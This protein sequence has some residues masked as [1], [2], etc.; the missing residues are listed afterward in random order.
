ME[1]GINADQNFFP[2]NQYLPPTSSDRNPQHQRAYDPPPLLNFDQRSPQLPPKLPFLTT[3]NLQAVTA[4]GYV[5]GGGDRDADEFYRE[6]R[7]VQQSSSS[8]T[9]MAASASES[10]PTV[11]PLRSNGN[12]TTPKHPTIPNART[13][14][15][16]AYRSASSPLDDRTG[17]NNAKSSP[18][19]NG[20]PNSRQPSV[21]DLLKRFDQNNSSSGSEA[22]KPPG[23]LATRGAN[24]GPGY[25]K[26][27]VGYQART[28]N[29]PSTA[30][31]SRIGAS[32]SHV[33]PNRQKSPAQTRTQR[34]RFATE[35]QHSNNTLSGAAR[36]TRPRNAPSGSIS[37]ASKSMVNLSPT[38]PNA[39]SQTPNRRPLFG[40]VIGQGTPDIAYGIPRGP[41]RRTSDSNL[42]PNSAHRRSKSDFDVS[43]SSPTAWYLGVTPALDDV[44]T[45]K[46]RATPGH[47]R[48]HS[49]FADTKVNTMNGVS[50][51]FQN[52]HSRSPSLQPSASRLPRATNRLSGGSSDSSSLPSTRANSPFSTKK[53]A[54]G[55]PPKPDQRPW[56]PAGRA[57]TPT[58]R[59]KTPT[60]RGLRGKSTSPGK[61]NTNSSLKAYISA[62]LLKTS[63]PLRSSR[64][65]QPV[66]SAA[67]AA[68]AKP[69]PTE[70]SSSP[71]Q[72]RSGMKL[73]RNMGGSEHKDRKISDT[74]LTKEDF[75]ARRAEI[76]RA[77]TKSIAL[78]D[79]NRIR[80]NNLRRLQERQA[81]DLA[82]AEAA[83]AAAEKLAEAP[84]EEPLRE[85][86]EE[87]PASQPPLHL[88]TSFQTPQYSHNERNQFPADQDSPTLGM[89]GTFIDD[90]EPASAISNAT[91]EIDN[92]P[93][94]E[95]ARLSR[96]P[97]ARRERSGLSSHVTYMENGLSAEQALFGSQH[98]EDEDSITI[99]LEPPTAVDAP[100]E[101][102]PTNNKFSRD[103]S[104]PGAYED[105]DY[106]DYNQPVFATTLT[107]ASPLD[108]TPGHSEAI[109]PL[110]VDQPQLGYDD[111]NISDASEPGEMKQISQIAPEI[112][113][114]QEP[115][116][117]IPESTE[118][119]PRF[120]LP[121]LRTALA[122]PSLT[123]SDVSHDY[124][125]TPGTDIEY[126]SSDGAAANA[127]SS[128]ERDERDGELS[129]G[130]KR[131][132]VWSDYNRE[133][134]A[135]Q[136][137][138]S[139]WTDY[140]VDT[141][142]EYSEREEHAQPPASKF[143]SAS[144]P[145]PP[146]PTE[147][148]ESTA[149]PQSKL[150]YSP[151]PSPRF[152]IGIPQRESSNRHQLPPLST[153]GS[154]A[155]E[156]SDSSP[157]FANIPLPLWPNYSP[158]PPPH[159]PGESSPALSG[160]SPPPPS[161]YNRRPP[162]SLYQSSQNGARNPESRRASDDL[163]SPR[164][165]SSTPRSS[166][167]ISFEESSADQSLKLKSTTASLANEEEV[168][169]AAKD[170]KR[171][172]R[173]RLVIKELIDTESVYLK[174]M[175]VVE[176]IYKGTAEACPKLETGDIKVIF[177]N[178]DEIV[179]FSTMFLDELKSAGSSVYSPRPT[180]PRRNSKGTASPIRDDRSS[181][182]PTLSEETDEQKDRKT[183]I[184]ANFGKH[185]KRMQVIY[186]DFLKNSEV[187]SSRL[188]ALQTDNSVKV[189]LGE[190]NLV[191]KDLT[192][193]WDLD[194]L[195]VKPVQ[196]ITRYQLLLAEIKKT[197]PDNHP[198]YEAL[199]LSTQELGTLLQN[200]DDLKK[201]I[202]M[203]GKIVGRKRKESDVRSGL[204]KAFGRAR[205]AKV[206]A[207][208]NRPRDDELYVKLHEKFGDDY[209]RL[210][211]VLRDVEFYTR[212]V[213][214]W[215]NDFLRYLSSMELIMRMTASPYPEL[216][217]KWARFNMSMRDMGT[218]A[219][220][221]HVSCCKPCVLFAD[222][223]S[224]DPQRP[225]EGHRTI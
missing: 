201:R 111:V 181:V 217:S 208:P 89:P 211:V 17:L 164:A 55:K 189:W 51:S 100:A 53:L 125:N 213:T 142:D 98:M 81:H 120:Q 106:T 138:T 61:I 117:E 219:L 10:R 224:S 119:A 1:S 192:A 99:M 74:Q 92:E 143:P 128:E 3:R 156:F 182:A 40:E 37:Q 200:I 42:Q 126:E 86:T 212:Q 178:T 24:A 193:A 52:S 14:L 216:E 11:S 123:P 210:Q 190:C 44:D 159:Q 116:H 70:P 135:E 87:P 28:T 50:P 132:S 179:A 175:N 136:K 7:G 67:T 163:Y 194:A 150:E 145:A 161:L 97:S 60:G 172:E 85:P 110:S 62:P 186:T 91:T 59:A 31:T 93:Q 221:D 94:T 133:L 25:A 58:N 101:P 154:F 127:V 157:G 191:A 54:N 65:R 71:K 43:P 113:L 151:L 56:S 23:R 68:A 73:T 105:D 19:L 162:S 206:Q 176:E 158:P 90:D 18:A 112:S 185:L 34:T 33:P 30:G 223:F 13:G 140:S 124:L 198:D 84:S 148:A 122:P 167:Q 95:A 102:T 45:N 180:K 131:R 144:R 75:A 12:G 115:E 209:L 205:E 63:P 108:S 35:D 41:T 47:N 139:V 96:M 147:Q 64:P 197:T 152:P 134:S 168:K 195:L 220:E 149:E 5:G 171:L 104:P 8:F 20:Y 222:F 16:P 174:D 169:V 173:R 130:Q 21:K 32:T 39:P 114:Q 187:A 4:N 155:Q 121:M 77:Y 80:A 22:P 79:Q 146:P 184:G 48:N 137:R 9:D 165:S 109:S 46:T 103:P 207:N 214:N 83:K 26:E 160:R 129:P 76:H 88:T 170:Q 15:K 49:D 188:A 29:T 6:Y 27:R 196:R 141:G 166:T 78:E 36:P 57:V 2:R 199:A 204:A 82:V 215:T 177:R 118:E 107:A 38:S 153:S 203:V 218:I 225:Q 72:A 66:S 183:F 202:H 69:K